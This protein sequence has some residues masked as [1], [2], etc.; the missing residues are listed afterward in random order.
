MRPIKFL[1]TLLAFAGTTATAVV[2]QD[3]AAPVP[4]SPVADM[5]IWGGPIYTAD[6]ANPSA[7]AVAIKDGV[8]I[9]VGTRADAEA[10]VGDATT[11]LSLD[12]AALYPGFVDAHAHLHG[13]GERELTLNLEGID[14]LSGVKKAV[15]D[16][17]TKEQPSL[18]VGRGWIETHW[19]E[20]RFP[21]R[22]DIDAVVEDIPVILTRAD[23]HAVVAN[24]KALEM[25]GITGATEAPYGGEIIKNALGEPT[26]ILVDTAMSLVSGLVPAPTDADV[27]HALVTGARVYAEYGWT[28][29]HNMSVPIS[30][31]DALERLADAG[32]VDIRVYNAIEPE[33]APSLFASG[34]R[35]NADGRIVTRAIKLYMDGALGSRGAALLEPYSDAA[36]SG[37]LITTKEET[38]PIL[39][40]ALGSGIQIAMHAIGDRG[41]RLVLDWF[42]EAFG[43]VPT[44]ERAIADPRWRD[45]HTQ[46]VHPDDLPR[47]AQLGVIASMQPSHAIGDLHFAPDRLGDDRLVGAYAWSSLIASGAV[48]AG[49]S[50]APVERGD[51]MIEFYAAVHRHDLK[52][53]QG[54]NWHAEE[55]VTRTEAL[56]MFTL[57]PAY[58]A[59]AEDRLGSITVGKEADL[60]AFDRDIMTAVPADIPK[61]KA[62]LTVVKGNVAYMAE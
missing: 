9:H 15:A 58:A 32:D 26:G 35:Q 19:P 41:N 4:S 50:D 27:D 62:I 38:M 11:V 24:S 39:K 54:E 23:G 43:D 33:D 13:I 30:R 18:L 14:S 1:L 3:T 20:K 29:L 40:Q 57:W 17:R 56:K 31:V 16:W 36:S 22:W 34:M 55:A 60:T 47:Y 52:G 46:I 42:E 25:A 59:F 10:L 49:G 8:F 5:V 12:G 48:V 21:T 51:P 44:I 37:L 53:F 2:A 28:G 6:D 7:E 45:E 61:T